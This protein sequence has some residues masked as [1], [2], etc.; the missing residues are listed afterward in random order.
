MT[1]ATFVSLAV[2]A[3]LQW[4][5]VVPTCSFVAPRPCSIRQSKLSLA[6]TKTSLDQDTTWKMKFLLQAPTEQ[7]KKVDQIFVIDVQFL[8]EDGYEPPQGTVTQIAG[9]VEN[10]NEE[11]TSETSRLRVIKSRWQLSEDPNDRKDGL[12]VW[13]LFKVSE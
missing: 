13:G 8:E 9:F 3:L 2:L 10:Q 7:G 4:A 1:T 5:L 6:A 11:E 12:W